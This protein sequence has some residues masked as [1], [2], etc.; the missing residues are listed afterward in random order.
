[1]KALEAV[2]RK[3]LEALIQQTLGEPAPTGLG[4]CRINVSRGSVNR[5]SRHREMGVRR[6]GVLVAWAPVKGESAVPLPLASPVSLVNRHPPCGQRIRNGTR[7]RA[8]TVLLATVT[9]I[10]G[11]GAVGKQTGLSLFTLQTR[12]STGLKACAPPKGRWS[13]AGNGGDGIFSWC[14]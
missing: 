12:C 14:F 8:F 11:Y 2:G 4:S 6:A 3:G 7:L 5:N 1:M 13:G 10:C 9:C